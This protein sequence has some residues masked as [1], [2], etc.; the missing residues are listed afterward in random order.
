MPSTGVLSHWCPNRALLPLPWVLND[1]SAYGMGLWRRAGSALRLTSMR[2][3]SGTGR[4]RYRGAS[5][6][7][8][9][10]WEMSGRR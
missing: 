9:A 2:S 1:G 8:C 10:A 3:P 5:R 6:V 4:S 7:A